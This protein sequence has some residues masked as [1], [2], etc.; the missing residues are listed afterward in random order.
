MLQTAPGVT[1]RSHQV[2]LNTCWSED[3]LMLIDLMIKPTGLYS[4]SKEMSHVLKVMSKHVI[5]QFTWHE[6]MPVIRFCNLHV[7]Y[8]AM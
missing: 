6:H 2:Q 3:T 4:E 7:T 1:Q 8:N 5:D